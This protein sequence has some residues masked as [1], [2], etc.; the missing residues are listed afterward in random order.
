MCKNCV[1]KNL[2]QKK[3]K[4]KR[5]RKR[6]LERKTR[7]P[8]IFFHNLAPSPPFSHLSSPR[9]SS[10]H[11]VLLPLRLA[12]S[13]HGPKLRGPL[14]P[15]RE[16]PVSEEGNEYESRRNGRGV[17]MVRSLAPLLQNLDLSKTT[18]KKKNSTPFHSRWSERMKAEDPGYFDR[19]KNQQAP[20][21]LWIGCADSRVPVRIERV[22]FFLSPSTA[23]RPVSLGFRVGGLFSWPERLF[24]L[25]FFSLFLL[26]PLLFPLSLSR[27]STKTGQ[28]NPRPPPRRG[29][30][31]G[32]R[33]REREK[34]YEKV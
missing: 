17:S 3:K 16:Q 4:K 2:N 19:L 15:S 29:L 26:T 21:Y 31:P 22:C 32:K 13:Q 5:I 1:K 18:S 33:E 30:C 12:H 6:E 23:S 14:V 20:K 27:I 34:G 24:F 28:P 25:S 11:V 7:E 8:R 10:H 9:S